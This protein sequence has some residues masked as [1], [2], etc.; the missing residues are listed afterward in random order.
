MTAMQPR[1]PRTKDVIPIQLA[2]DGFRG[3]VNKPTLFLAGESGREHVN[4]KPV[5][6]QRGI[7]EFDFN[8]DDFDMGFGMSKFTNKKG[9]RRRKQMDSIE[10]VLGGFL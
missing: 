10:T 2:G 8:H 7:F 4:I 6:K 3:F 9:K 1:E 5:H